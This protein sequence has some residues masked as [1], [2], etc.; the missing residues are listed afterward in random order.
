M[1]RDLYVGIRRHRQA[2]RREHDRRK[3]AAARMGRRAPRKSR[4]LWAWTFLVVLFVL[5]GAWALVSPS[6]EA[7]TDGP[8]AE[9]LLMPD[10][11]SLSID[12]AWE[13][14]D[15]AKI[16][17][18]GDDVFHDLSARH[19]TN[20]AGDWRVAQQYPSAGTPVDV[21][22]AIAGWALKEPEY[23]FFNDHPRMPRSGWRPG[24]VV[25]ANESKALRGLAD[26]VE[27]RFEQGRTPQ[28]ATK[29]SR[30]PSRT[31]RVPALLDPSIEPRAERR[32]RERLATARTGN[33]FVRTIPSTGASLRPGQ[34]ITIVVRPQ[35][36]DHP[37]LYAPPPAPSDEDDDYYVYLDDDDDD[38]NVPGWLCPTRF[39]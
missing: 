8:A 33:L 22:S 21:G 9:Q 17:W 4:D 29:T 23:Q 32:A 25:S 19:R 31:A 5:L 2:A 35:P 12:Q 39:C 20:V 15:E 10:L 1:I 34:F 27:L 11:A 7:E 3:A 37:E 18:I 16:G 14:M 28:S 36:Q 6:S 13:A 24:Q 26:L 30:W 38:F